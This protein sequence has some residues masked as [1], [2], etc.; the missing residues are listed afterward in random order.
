MPDLIDLTNVPV[1]ENSPTIEQCRAIAQGLA[2]ESGGELV[3]GWQMNDDTGEKE[4]GWCPAAFAGNAFVIE[5]LETLTPQRP[6]HWKTFTIFYLA[7]YEYERMTRQVA[8]KDADHAERR[9]RRWVGARHYK[10]QT[11]LVA[12]VVEGVIEAKD[13]S[14]RADGMDG[15]G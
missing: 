1:S 12:A 2:N 3:I 4:L 6:A 13:T 9:L 8:G 5:V 7:G 14:G 15:L 10:D 11:F